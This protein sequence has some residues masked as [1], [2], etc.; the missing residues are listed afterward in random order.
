MEAGPSREHQ[1][2]LSCEGTETIVSVIQ[3][4]LHLELSAE[5][6]TAHKLQFCRHAGCKY[7]RV[8]EAHTK[9]LETC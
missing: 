8:V 1:L 6:G 7:E 3:S 9:V 4:R 5:L 2:R